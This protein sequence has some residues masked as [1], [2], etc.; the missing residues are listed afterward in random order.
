MAKDS[1]KVWSAFSLVAALGSAAVAKKALDGGWKAATGKQPPAN[2]AD[3]DVD[4]WEAVAWAA[5]SGTFVALAKMLAQR[6][7]AGYYLKST[8]ELPP[9]L[10]KDA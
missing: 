2:P 1:S 5:A 10:R 7:A 3:P 4:V 9:G 8:G 6:K